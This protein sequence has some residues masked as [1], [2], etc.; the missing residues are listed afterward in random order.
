MTSD[1]SLYVMKVLRYF[2]H[3][4]DEVGGVLCKR[5][6]ENVTF[7]ILNRTVLGSVGASWGPS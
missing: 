6:V 7:S 1:N 5:K 2:I 3:G 4:G